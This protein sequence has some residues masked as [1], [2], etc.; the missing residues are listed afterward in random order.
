MRRLCCFTISI[1][2]WLGLSPLVFGQTQVDSQADEVL[3]A[4]TAYNS[5]L[6]SLVISAEITEESVYGDTHKLQFGG[7]LDIGIRRPASFFA[8]V[9]SDLE[10]RRMYLSDGT[11]TVFDEDVNVY[12]QA[13][14]PG[15]LHEVFSQ[16]YTNYGISSPGGE[17]FS[18]SAYELLVGNAS[19]VIYVGVGNVNGR[20]CHHIA[21]ILDDMDWQ[22]WVRKGGDPE[23]C[24]YVVT[25]RD[26]PMAPQFS[27]TITKWA[28]NAA[29]SDRQFRFQAPADAE[30]IEFVK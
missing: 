24:K 27:I 26:V 30:A 29:I 6:S 2:L 14:V 7:T 15:N 28:A 25:D 8:V 20:D 4:V 23:L 5:R 22:L 18:G 17:L 13:P 9:Q 21:G 11:F 3:K 19:S 16:L 10:N 12:A 1:T